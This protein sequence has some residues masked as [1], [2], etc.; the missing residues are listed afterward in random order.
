MP[1]VEKHPGRT[2]G[3]RYIA[4]YRDP[5]GRKRS[6]G[7]FSSRRAAERAAHQVDE[8]VLDRSWVDP[9]HGKITF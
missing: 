9:H 2:G 8:K 3:T 6:A 7:T 1:W 5:A 4:V